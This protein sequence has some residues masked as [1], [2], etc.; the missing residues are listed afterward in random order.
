[1]QLPDGCLLVPVELPDPA[2]DFAL[3]E[4]GEDHPDYGTWLVLVEPLE[5][6]TPAPP[7]DVT[8]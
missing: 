2:D 4:I 7:G 5:D 3:V 6:P 1:L 8:P